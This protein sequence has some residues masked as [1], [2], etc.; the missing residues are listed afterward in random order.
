MMGAMFNIGF[1]EMIILLA[2]GLI[3]IGP[4]QL[5]Q[6]ARTVAK[7]IGELR[8]AFNDVKTTVGDDLRFKNGGDVVNKVKI[9]LMERM[10]SLEKSKAQG[11]PAAQ[12]PAQTQSPAEAVSK[13]VPRPSNKET[14]S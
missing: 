8:K 3:V 11:Q 7:L 12:A 4:K 10:D 9:E 5:P 14:K 1:G 6:V 2:I 13:T